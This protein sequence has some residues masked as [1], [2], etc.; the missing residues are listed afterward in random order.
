MR[1]G[2]QALPATPQN[3]Q[4]S[5]GTP[6]QPPGYPP[7]QQS[8]LSGLQGNPAAMAA[9]LQQQQQQQQQQHP[10]PGMLRAIHQQHPAAAAAA[11]APQGGQVDMQEIL[12]RLGNYSK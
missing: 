1:N 2:G 3:A 12:A 4:P 8:N 6:A 7:Q 11:S 10:Q 9:F 5:Y